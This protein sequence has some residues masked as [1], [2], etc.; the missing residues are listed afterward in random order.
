M[1]QYLN[2]FLVDCSVKL[3][4][5]LHELLDNGVL[6]EVIA[7]EHVVEWCKGSK[8]Y[9]DILLTVANEYKPR[10]T[11]TFGRWF[12]SR[13]THLEAMFGGYIV[14]RFP[15]ISQRIYRWAR[16]PPATPAPADPSLSDDEPDAASPALDVEDNHSESVANES[17]GQAESLQ[18]TRQGRPELSVVYDNHSESVNRYLGNKELAKISRSQ[19]TAIRICIIT[20]ELNYI[21]MK[22]PDQV[23]AASHVEEPSETSSPSQERQ[24]GRTGEED[25]SAGPCELPALSSVPYHAGISTNMEIPVQLWM[26]SHQ[27][28]TNGA[29]GDIASSSSPMKA[30]DSSEQDMKTLVSQGIKPVEGNLGE[31]TKIQDATRLQYQY[32]QLPDL[33]KNIAHHQ[34]QSHQCPDLRQNVLHIQISPMSQRITESVVD[35]Q[36]LGTKLQ[37]VEQFVQLLRLHLQPNADI[38]NMLETGL[39]A[40]IEHYLAPIQERV[41]M[42]IQYLEEVQPYIV[43]GQ[44]Q[45]HQHQ[46]QLL[47]CHQH[48]RCIHETINQIRPHD[49][50]THPMLKDACSKT[51]ETS[52]SDLRAAIQCVSPILR[53]PTPTPAQPAS[54]SHSQRPTFPQAFLVAREDQSQLSLHRAIRIFPLCQIPSVMDES[55]EQYHLTAHKGWT[56][57]Y[58]RNF[59]HRHR[60]SIKRVTRAMNYVVRGAET[61]ASIMASIP[62]HPGDIATSALTSLERVVD[63][64]DRLNRAGINFKDMLS[65]QLITDSHQKEAMMELLFGATVSDEQIDVAGNGNENTAWICNH[66]LACVQKGEPID[67][68]NYLTLSQYEPLIKREPEVEVILHNSMS[69]M[70]L[71]KTFSTQSKTHKIIIRIEPAYF[72]TRTEGAPRNSIV[73]MFNELGRALKRQ[74]ALIHLEIHG[75]SV[76]GGVFAGLR[77]VL[78]CQSLENLHISGIPCFLQENITIKCQ[79]LRVLTLQEVLVD[80]EQAVG[81]LAILMKTNSGLTSITLT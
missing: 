20:A 10:A 69:V 6:G 51:P 28:I 43:G 39:R 17:A 32:H 75:N 7:H 23:P 1:L 45:L 65:P 12:D 79:R 24:P 38:A 16:T 15:S 42:H 11:V 71:T 54:S 27:H 37:G 19:P 36:A 78:T 29:E 64:K 8:P 40:L 26:Y 22:L 74:K 47:Q 68:T 62:S 48:L 58:P 57:K 2:T 52:H 80:T 46:Q 50:M 41:H 77:A 14:I 3:D 63:N 34:Q 18:E 66:C 9:A 33:Q 35:P 31:L 5:L 44:Q 73:H 55:Q 61:A 76:D 53:P 81:N 30:L 21:T 49:H 56:V 72:E 59:E 60:K 67:L 70:V 25:A 13:K 4:D